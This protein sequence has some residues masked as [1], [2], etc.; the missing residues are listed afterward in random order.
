M[1]NPPLY[2]DRFVLWGWVKTGVHAYPVEQFRGLAA[3]P[4]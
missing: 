3:E 4:V 2:T 1:T